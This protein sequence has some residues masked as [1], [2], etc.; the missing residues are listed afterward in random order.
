MA[1]NRS[2]G[3]H[4]LLSHLPKVG[5]VHLHGVEKHLRRGNIGKCFLITPEVPHEN[6]L[7]YAQK[8]EPLDIIISSDFREERKRIEGE[9]P[10]KKILFIDPYHLAERD[11]M[12]DA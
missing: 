2:A 5:M 6:V 7:N 8:I 11:S 1:A 12:L 3:Q 10:D 9:N 4:I